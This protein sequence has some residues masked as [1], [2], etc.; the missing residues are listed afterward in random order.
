MMRK[1]LL[2]IAY[3]GTSYCGFQIQPNG[4]SVE[5]I[6]NENLSRIAGHDVKV[7]GA[8]RTDAG[9]HALGQRASF[10]LYGNIPTENIPE[11]VNGLLPNDIV[12]LEAKEVSPDFNCRYD[13]KLKHYRYS[14]RNT[15]FASP[16]DYDTSYY[17]PEKLNLDLM[18]KAADIMVG[19]HSFEAFTAANS[20][21][22]NFIRK[23]DRI[24]IIEED[25]Y[26]Y[27]DVFGAGFLYK[28]VRSLAGALIDVGRGYLD[29]NVIAEALQTGDRSVLSLTAPGRGLCLISIDYDADCLEKKS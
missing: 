21:R 5:E 4:T 6:L 10:D 17:F 14:V 8:G 11:A 20:G 27:I 24:D 2:T 25:P 19:E 12:V 13:A 28:M 23:V 16:F 26:V 15:D 9:V 29:K 7:F 1:I 3:K 22:T 18:R